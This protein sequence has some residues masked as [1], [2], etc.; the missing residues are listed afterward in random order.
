M[1]SANVAP[2][3]VNCVL[4]HTATPVVCVCVCVRVYTYF[5]VCD[6]I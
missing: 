2:V 6:C 5:H 4:S 1:C 3:K